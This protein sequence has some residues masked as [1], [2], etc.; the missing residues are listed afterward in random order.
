[1]TQVSN[2]CMT[3]LYLLVGF[4]CLVVRVVAC[5][6]L[7]MHMLILI[8]CSFLSYKQLMGALCYSPV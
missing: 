5:M 8:S 2:F 4:F 3:V 6:S 7:I 1:M